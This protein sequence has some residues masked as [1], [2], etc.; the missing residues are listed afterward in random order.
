[1][2]PISP[3]HVKRTI[4]QNLENILRYNLRA[5]FVKL[6]GYFNLFICFLVVELIRGEETQ[7]TASMIAEFVAYSQVVRL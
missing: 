1:M 2:H 5:I 7:I 6:F 3:V 4:I